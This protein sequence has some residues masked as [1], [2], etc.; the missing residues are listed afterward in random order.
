M[1][2]MMSIYLTEDWMHGKNMKKNNWC[3]FRFIFAFQTLAILIGCQTKPSILPAIDQKVFNDYWN[4][5]KAEISSYDLTQSRYGSAYEGKVV[6]IFVQEDMSQSKQVKLDDPSK[7]ST[8][9]IKVMKMNMNKEFITGIYKY[10]MM[11]SVFTPIEYTDYPHSLKAVASSQDWCGQTF[12]QYNWKGNRYEVQQMSYFESEGDK[13][14]ELTNA[15]LEDEIWTKIR[16][17]PNTLPVG[18]TEMIPSSFYIRLSHQQ[19]KIY[20]AETSLKPAGDEYTYTIY[21]PELK[22]TMEIYF[23]SVFP[24]KIIGWKETYG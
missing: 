23:Q 22:R 16:V 3:F 1:D 13:S 18:E 6:L 12:T 9:D 19:N 4:Q 11:N 10:S 24:F 7:H 5:D 21:Y 17:A 2:L 8:D 20:M 15:W 14:Y